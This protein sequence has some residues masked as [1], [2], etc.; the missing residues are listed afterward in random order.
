M[1]T[2]GTARA[3]PQDPALARSAGRAAASPPAIVLRGA[4]RAYGA[5][6]AIEPLSL[7]I[8]AGE[9]VAIV[10]PSGAGKST[11]LRLMNTSLAPSSGSVEVLGRDVARLAPRELR[12]LRARIGTIHQQLLL[13]PQASV[14]QN[15]VAGRLG[16]VPLAG[17]LLSL[18]SRREAERVRAVLE[19]LGIPEKIFERV[20]RL[21]G[22]EQQRVAIA[23][24]LYQS[25]EVVIADEPLASV[26]PARSAEIIER[27]ART[28]AG[29][30]V[31]VTTHR[32]EPFLAHVDRVVGLRAGSLAFDRP[33]AAL[34]LDDL[35]DLYASGR[36][37]R[38]RAEP[39]AQGPSPPGAPST[40]LT[41]AAS[42]T[43]GEFLLPAGVRAFVRAY[44]GVRVS[45]AVKD[46][47][48]VTADVLAGR[49]ELGFVG[50]RA[51]HPGLCFEEFAEDEIVLLSAPALEGLP[52][53][54]VAPEVVAHLPRVDREEGSGT[55]AIVE[56]H[57]ANLGVPLAPG[58]VALQVGTV[59]GVKAAVLSGIGVAFASRAAV[60]DD[61]EAG[62]LCAV[63]IAGV[64]IPRRIFACWR[65]EPGPSPAARRFLEVARA[66]HAEPGSA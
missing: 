56:E 27:L 2:D 20:D 54:P 43:P 66:A 61:L 40:L 62:H 13:V 18:L 51:A 32:V 5:L 38:A 8:R 4:T 41:L 24:A 34:T 22:G 64:R 37:A 23:R 59:I 7:A 26:D 55:R 29:R 42:S 60:R 45:L 58:A 3:E 12:A 28:F 48:E 35:A 50:A 36:A 19:E 21:S 44:P 25:P 46:S 15:V 9:R 17:A 49:A 52:P 31:V 11:L 10:G 57:F 39:R 53:E 30:T 65:A 1:T 16:Q 63:R 14:M 47:A 33:S 6:R